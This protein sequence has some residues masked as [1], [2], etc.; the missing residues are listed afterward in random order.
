[1]SVILPSS[2]SYG[3]SLPALPDNT[4][5]INV[6]G[7]STNGSSFQ[8]GQQIYLDL[9]NRGFLVPDSMYLSY[10]YAFTNTVG[11][12]AGVFGVPAV[13]PFGR[14]DCQ[15]GSQT[16]DTIQ[17]YNLF[18]HWLVNVSMD[19]AQKYGNQFN[20]GYFASTGVPS[21]EQLDGR[22]LTANETGSFSFPLV[23]ILSNAE[24]LLPLFAMPQV[25]LVLTMDSLANFTTSIT[26]SPITG[27]TISN[28]QLRY[29]VIDF[30]GSVEQLVLSSADKLYI[31]SQSFSLAAQSL[32]ANS[33]GSIE[34]VYN[35][36]YASI[37]SVFSLCG[38]NKSANSDNGGFFDAV[39]LTLNNG[40]Y[41][42][43]I[44]GQP[45]PAQPISTRT[46][47]AQAMLELRSAVGSI[48]D[49]NNNMSINTV[50]YS[51]ANGTDSDTTVQAPSKYFLGT[52]T[53]RL[54]SNNLL[55]G[56]SSQN[57]PISFRINTGTAIGTA[58]S[59][60]TLIVNYDALIEV[61]TMTRQ[62][63]VKS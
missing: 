41:Q 63:S 58:N 49:K 11:A 50:E 37:K 25:R 36:R 62:V 9:I 10:T 23:S 31:K 32:P 13:A 5:C 45:Y 22:I 47:K 33:I 51:Y 8:P 44:G 46:G 29:K 28:V 24:K 30:S 60:V 16:I 34:L 6:V 52:S 7:T 42:W 39:D 43:S 14:L 57:S 18:Y 4:N 59:L 20:L 3:E 1:M 15:V 53:E 2:I 48:F 40:E 27:L 56:I 17:Q 26:A 61:D 21:L 38:N 12:T 55:T 35:V 19:V 54:N